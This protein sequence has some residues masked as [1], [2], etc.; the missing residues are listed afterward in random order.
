MNWA[1]HFE[2]NRTHHAVIPWDHGITVESWLREPLISSLQCFQLGESGEGWHL[3][4]HAI[5]TGD[6]SYVTAID[7]FIGEEQE[8]ARLMA[9]VLGLLGASLI[10]KHWSNRCFIVLRRLFGLREELLVLLLPEMIAKPYFRALREGVTDR[11]LQLV[12]S[13]ILQDE[14]GHLAFHADTLNRMLSGIPFAQRL[15]FQIWWR[16]A[17]RLACIVVLLGHG[18]LLRTVHVSRRDFW[19]DC[20]EIFDEV[21][22]RVF[23]PAH[24]LCAPCLEIALPDCDAGIGHRLR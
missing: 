8:H 5:R 7:L 19:R 1:R 2:E 24:V 9:R 14:E 13:Q 20:G 10:S 17:F 18:A 4:G 16:I 21:A 23:S 11:V 22:A 15:C 3:R 6:A 12:F